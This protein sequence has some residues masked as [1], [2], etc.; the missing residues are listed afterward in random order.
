MSDPFA[1]L[2]PTDRKPLRREKPPSWIAPMLAT[3]SD[4]RFSRRDWIYERKLDGE[5]ALV[6]IAKGRVR[7][8]SR[9]RRP[10]NDTYPELADELAGRGPADAVAD[11]EIVAF[12]GGVTSFSR[13]QQ[14]MQIEDPDE[15]RRSPVA[16]YLYLFD[17]VHLAGRSL[18]DLPL[19]SRKT[20]LKRAFT[21][22]GRL[23]WT[24]HRREDGALRYAGKVGT[25]FADDQL[26]RLRRR[27]DRIERRTSPFA[28]T[29]PSAHV[30]WVT[31]RLVGEIGFTEWTRDG[32]LRHPRFLG[33][34]RDKDPRD[35]VRERPDD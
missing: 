21:Y 3:L 34:R 20:L 5:R 32:R 10:L 33:L 18:R 30:H 6:F 13:L 28:G 19:I 26:R 24:P 1:R 17:L 15:A 27:L 2:S 4:D 23:R 7:L 22:G 25:G 29:P 12:S 8:M 9:N 11:G 31:P 16:A 35:V 14:R